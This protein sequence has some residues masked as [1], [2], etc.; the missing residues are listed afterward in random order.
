[1][2]Q[3]VVDVCLLTISSYFGRL[4]GYAS[5]PF[6]FSSLCCLIMNRS[7]NI[8]CWNVRGLNDKDKWSLLRNKIEESGANIFCFWETK[9]ELIDIRFLKN[10]APKRFDN[11]EFCSSTGASG[12]ILVACVSH[13]SL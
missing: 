13:S 7:W 11:F 12:G 4:G 6:A 10:F 3:Y 9:R 5:L 2:Q 1:L 8:L